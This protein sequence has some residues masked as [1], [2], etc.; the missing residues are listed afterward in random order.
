MESSGRI[1]FHWNSLLSFLPFAAVYF[2]SLHNRCV[3]YSPS[4]VATDDTT[5]K[6]RF[7][8]SSAKRKEFLL[9]KLLASSKRS[10]PPCKSFHLENG[11]MVFCRRVDW[12]VQDETNLSNRWDAQQCRFHIALSAEEFQEREDHSPQIIE[13]FPA[14]NFGHR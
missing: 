7:M 12:I 8:V 4:Y 13:T 10:G 6:W 9:D 5:V 2:Y 14:S 11:D 3:L 1:Q